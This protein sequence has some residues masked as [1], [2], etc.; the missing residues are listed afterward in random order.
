MGRY[1]TDT[2]PKIKTHTGTYKIIMF[3]YSFIKWGQFLSYPVEYAIL[4]LV[5]V[6]KCGD[7]PIAFLETERGYVQ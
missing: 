4:F 2:L 1:Q 3:K 7:S 6:E 5:G